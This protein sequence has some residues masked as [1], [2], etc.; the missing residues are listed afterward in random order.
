MVLWLKQC[1]NAVQQ[2]AENKIFQIIRDRRLQ[3]GTIKMSKLSIIAWLNRVF[4]CEGVYLNERWCRLLLK[5]SARS[6]NLPRINKCLKV[7]CCSQ[8]LKL[9]HWRITTNPTYKKCPVP[10]VK[11]LR[12]QNH[13]AGLLDHCVCPE[14]QEGEAGLL[15]EVLYN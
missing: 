9:Q 1:T 8:K 11:S 3:T 10:K 5:K 15:Y 2:W 14:T 7:L 12:L 13:S 6:A 4:L